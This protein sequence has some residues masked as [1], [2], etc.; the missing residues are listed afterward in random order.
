LNA[1]GEASSVEVLVLGLS[2]HPRPGN[3]QR[4]KGTAD[5]PTRLKRTKEL[6]NRTGERQRKTKENKTEKQ[7]EQRQRKTKQNKGER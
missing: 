2:W 5:E 6:K 7:K 3:Q 1:S 4:E